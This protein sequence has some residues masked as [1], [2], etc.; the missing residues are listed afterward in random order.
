MTQW[1]RFIDTFF[2]WDVMVQYLPAIGRGFVVTCELAV[3]VVICGISLGLILALIRSYQIKIINYSIICLVD[4]LRSLPPLVLIIL[5]YFGLPNVGL[6][7]SGF[8]VVILVLSFVL[9]SFAEEIFWAGITSI[10]KGQWEAS[11]STG[12]GYSQTLI[13]V[14]LP[15]AIRMTIPPLTNRTIAITKNTALGM[16]V[17]VGEILNQATT[18]QSFSS[19]ASPLMMGAI[20]Y[21]LLF[22]PIVYLGRRI[23]T[24][25][26][27]K[28]N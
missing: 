11:R 17:G 15:Q 9:G 24:R 16:V 14:I 3:L 13:Y 7:F 23:E 18:A 12:L 28:K 6:N 26:A 20:A 10:H 25:F 19:N 5:F 22:V 2:K 21:V 4:I 27:W 1:E 8:M